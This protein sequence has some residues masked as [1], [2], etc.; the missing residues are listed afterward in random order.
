MSVI[1][2]LAAQLEVAGVGT[3]GTTIFKSQ[4]PDEPDTALVLLAT[5][6]APPKDVM[7][8]GGPAIDYPRVQVVARATGFVAADAL[9]TQAYDAL[10][11]ITNQTLS[12]TYYLRV[13]ALQPP[14]QLDRDEKRRA[15]VAF[16]VEA[17]RT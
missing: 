12:G 15:L 1:D 14:F 6:G 5:P 17:E 11:A 9:A 8:A 13:V 3:V 4:L 10:H 16:N 7:G 2:D